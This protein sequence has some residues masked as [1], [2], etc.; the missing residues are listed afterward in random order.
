MSDFEKKEQ[1]LN[2]LLD[3]LN[4][5][6]LSYSQPSFEL[7][8]IKKEK[9]ELFHKKKRNRKTKSRVNEGA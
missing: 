1:N 5:L 7:E 2:Q 4:S 6:S 8:K 9:N 3:K